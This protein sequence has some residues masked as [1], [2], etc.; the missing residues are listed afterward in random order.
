MIQPKIFTVD[1]ASS[2]LIF[3]SE[4]FFSIEDLG[5][6]V[7]DYRRSAMSQTSQTQQSKAASLLSPQF[8]NGVYIP[9][10][11]LILG[12]GI[13][14]FEWLPFAI[15]VSLVLGAW[16]IY[17]V[18]QHRLLVKEFSGRQRTNPDHQAPELAP[19][20]EK[21]MVTNALKPDVF[22]KFPLKEKTVLSH[23]V[24]M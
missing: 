12:V 9:S 7:Q 8:I 13:V 18:G 20:P 14:K 5:Y 10:G 16:K 21:M 24:A 6:Q 19:V 22:Q 23:N 15:A 3:Y 4:I 2:F 17:S 1:I 11:L